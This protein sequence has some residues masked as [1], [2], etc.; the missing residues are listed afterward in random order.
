MEK[1]YISYSYIQNYLRDYY[2]RHKKKTFPLRAIENI[3]KKELFS[4][5]PLQTHFSRLWSHLSDETFIDLIYNL[6]LPLP[7]Q[8]SKKLLSLKEIS[9]ELPE[10][11]FFQ[12]TGDVLVFS[13]FHFIDDPLHTHNYF[14]IFY[15]FKGN[16]QLQFEN[17]LRTLREGD[18]CIIAPDSLHS[19]LNDDESSTIITISVRKST[20]DKSFFSLLTQK[21]L[22]SNFFYTILYSENSSNYLLFST[23]NDEDVKLIIKNIV[24]EHNR[25]D[26]Y[27]NTG[28][29]SWINLL[30]S[31]ILRNYS[32]SAEFYNYNLSN[33]FKLIMQYIKC[34]YR[35][36]S[37]NTLAIFFHYNEPYLSSVIKEHT[38]LSFI[39]LITNLKMS[40]SENLLKNTDMSIEKISELVGYNSCD[41]FSRTFKKHYGCSPRRYR[42]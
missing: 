23:G 36:L 42:K 5:T 3:D 12:I 39:K 38:G 8:E 16:C 2:F 28:C 17:E 29:I 19:L 26:N 25:E 22:L 1:Q 14:E 20:F 24:M 11:D 30:F 15:V 7:S 40:D 33:N 9:D 10:T 32:D 31:L 34:N 41:H 37:L 4:Y 27:T 6:K 35:F 18:L 13:Q 21:D